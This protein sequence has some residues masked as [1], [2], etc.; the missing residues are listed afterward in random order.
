LND[1]GAVAA[2]VNAKV[3]AL[4]NPRNVV[5]CGA[6]DR[7]GNWAQRV[8]RNVKRYGFEGPVYPFNP[9]R[10]SVWDTRCYRS[11]G[12]LPERPDHLVVLIP[13]NAVSQTLIDAAAAGARR[14]GLLCPGPTVSA[15]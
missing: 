2:D 5:I 6:S 9:R 8:W 4:L 12:E 1:V 15:T 10:D 11:F 13:A 14:R 7:P 3:D